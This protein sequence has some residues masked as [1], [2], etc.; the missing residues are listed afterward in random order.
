VTEPARRLALAIVAALVAL[1]VPSAALADRYDD[2]VVTITYTGSLKTV[3]NNSATQ[4]LVTQVDWDLTWTGTVHDLEHKAQSFTVRK[5]SGATAAT[6]PGNAALSCSAKLSRRTGAKIPV[7]GGRAPASTLLTAHAF[8][9]STA[10]ELQNDDVSPGHLC[11][12]YPTVY[13]SSPNL[14]PSVEL[15]LDGGIPS[16]RKPF[17]ASYNGPAGSGTE[18]DTLTSTL[19]LRI[20]RVAGGPGKQSGPST[21]EAVRRVAR[22]GILWDLPVAGYSCFVA[23]TGVVVLGTSGP[24]IGVLVGGTLTGVAGPVC[25]RL[26]QAIKRFAR[27]YDDPPVGHF[28]RIARVRR[29]SPPKLD[30]PRC[31]S[32][33]AQARATCTRLTRTARDYVAAVQRVTDVAS[34]LAITVG[35]ESAARKAGHATSAKRQAHRALALVPTLRAAARAQSRAGAAFATA[36]RAAGASGQMTAE[37]DAAGNEAALRRLVRAGVA[38]NEIVAVAGAALTPAPLDVLAT[39]GRKL[40]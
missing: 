17:N 24:A 10:E 32:G 5:L 40:G 13:G 20:G 37:Q 16:V 8:A 27:T 2:T 33:T 21:P 28:D 4:P 9:P 31:D 23:G 12:T 1:L 29:S 39:L 30:L 25:A 7:S 6:V 26:I 22:K 36:L 35:R 15:R 11:D 14:Q 34:T 38:R 19:E 3:R 18:T